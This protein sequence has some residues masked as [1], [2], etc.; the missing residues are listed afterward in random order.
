MLLTRLYVDICGPIYGYGCCFVLNI[1]ID[2][3]RYF[4]HPRA[5]NIVIHNWRKGKKKKPAAYQKA[6]YYH[7]PFEMAYVSS[8]TKAKTKNVSKRDFV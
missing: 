6:L 3:D 5:I 4:I 8:L 7:C 2:F 1:I